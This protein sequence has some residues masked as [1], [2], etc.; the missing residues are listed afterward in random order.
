MDIT[1]FSVVHTDLEH[2]KF[3]GNIVMDLC[4]CFQ[5]WHLVLAWGSRKELPRHLNFSPGKESNYFSQLIEYL[6]L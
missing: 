1:A 2:S 5:Q 4:R 3:E 6:S